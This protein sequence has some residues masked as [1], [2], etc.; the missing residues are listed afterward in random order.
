[1]PEK[2]AHLNGAYYGPS[3]L[4]TH[5]S[6][7]RPGRRGFGG[8]GCCCCLFSFLFKLIF[9][10][11]VTIG[12]AILIFW[13]V[14]RPQN[15]K[16]HVT[17]AT[18]TR[19]NYTNNTLNYD[20]ALN[21][22]IRNPNKRIGVYYDAMELRG[23]YDNLIFE[24]KFIQP[25]YQGHKNT[26]VLTPSFEDQKQFLA[27]FD[28]QGYNEETRTG[29]YKIDMDLYVRVRFKLGKIKT[30]SLKPRFLCDLEV[31]L[32]NSNGTAVV[33]GAASFKRTKCDFDW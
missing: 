33:V 3:V 19:W 18:L 32:T 5:Q 12:L 29:V 6:Y 8:G 26:T 22:S 24:S 9:S 14:V 20:L 28:L 10:I 11:V 30:R 16:V 27:N 7:H 1:M 25:F 21:I 23:V 15:I 17:E 4:P 13:L 31:P 2:Q